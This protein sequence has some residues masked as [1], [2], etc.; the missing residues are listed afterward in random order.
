MA[1][2]LWAGQVRGHLPN[3]RT[4][5][6]AAPVGSLLAPDALFVAAYPRFA[7]GCRAVDEPGLAIVAVDT[8]TGAAAGLV[9]LCAR[10]GRHVAAIVGRHD[11]C[12]L[13]LADHAQL[14]LRHLAVILDPVASWS[15]GATSPYQLVDLRSADGFT[16]EHG[17]PLR[18][19]RCDG[20]AILR[21]AGYT[22]FVLPLGDPTDWPATGAA[23]W[24]ALPERVYLDERAADSPRAVVHAVPRDHAAAGPGFP[25][26]TIATGA[27]I[28]TGARDV[29]VGSTG[30]RQSRIT[31]VPGPRDHSLRLVT[32][33]DRVGT[34]ALHGPGRTLTLD[35]GAHALADGILL[36]RYARCDGTLADDA[37][38]SR[39]HALLIQLDDTLCVIDTASTNGTALPGLPADRLVELLPDRP[40]DV[41]LGTATTLRWRWR[42]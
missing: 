30:S 38:V 33:D 14:A 18:A 5:C 12:D 20:P 19:V 7:D 3:T 2:S 27:A 8:V 16:D 4:A 26:G 34:L 1:V 41:L 11:Q 35:V 42:S 21:C 36:G 40:T 10:V 17:R 28:A 6:M 13:Y 25:R 37:S 22:L 31:V 32:D 29:A 24:A 15:R 9:K 23:A 39:V